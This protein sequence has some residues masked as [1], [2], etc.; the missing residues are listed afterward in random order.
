MV[1]LLTPDNW[2]SPFLTA[3][4]YVEPCRTS[5]SSSLKEL[6][7][8]AEGGQVLTGPKPPLHI[9]GRCPTA[10]PSLL[11]HGPQHHICH[12]ELIPNQPRAFPQSGVHG[13]KNSSLLLTAPFSQL[14]H[15]DIHPA[16]NE[17]EVDSVMLLTKEREQETR[18]VPFS[19]NGAHCL[20]TELHLCLGHILPN[21]SEAQLILV[22]G[23]FPSLL[24]EALEKILGYILDGRMCVHCGQD[25]VAFTE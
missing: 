6:E 25:P 20:Y 4:H 13:A 17:G 5:C 1:L 2:T 11:E 15:G 9:G 23:L 16:V 18:D 12:S 14:K 19:F 3:D 10:T 21:Q 7:G 24:P 8:S 22:A